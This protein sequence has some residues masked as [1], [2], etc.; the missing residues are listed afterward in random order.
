MKKRLSVIM[1]S[2]VL[3][4]TGLMPATA[5]AAKP[6]SLSASGVVTSITNGDVFPA[7]DS[8]RYVVASRT[9]TGILSGDI[10]GAFTLDYK[11]NV[12]LATQA[13]NLHGTLQAGS[14]VLKVNGTIEPLGFAWFAPWGMYLPMLTISGQWTAVS[15]AKGNGDFA[16]YAVFIPTPEGHVAAVVASGITLTGK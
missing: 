5:L 3:V 4:L 10:N 2:L 9:I 16:A 14:Q 15:G 8:G 13:G 1:L 12:E 6:A 11:A 7:G